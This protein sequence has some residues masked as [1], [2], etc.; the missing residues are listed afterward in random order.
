[1]NCCAVCLKPIPPKRHDR[2]C[3]PATYCTRHC[4]AIG[5]G[6]WNRARRAEVDD[7]AVIRL[8][9]GSRVASTKAERVAA[10]AE[11]T[12]RGRS[13]SWI[14]AALHVAERSVCR[15]RAALTKGQAV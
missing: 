14:A 1:M 11:L 8:I 6:I 9:S 7:V 5:V 4:A 3:R 2:P 12:A 15:Y 13:A 10:V